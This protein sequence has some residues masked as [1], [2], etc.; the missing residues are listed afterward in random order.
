MMNLSDCS[1]SLAEPAEMPVAQWVTFCG[2]QSS[3]TIWS[4][5]YEKKGAWLGAPLTLFELLLEELEFE[6]DEGTLIALAIGTL[7]GASGSSMAPNPPVTS[8][9]RLGVNSA[10]WGAAQG[11]LSAT[12]TFKN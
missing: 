6:L 12:P 7:L 2:P 5:P 10:F 9:V 11:V 8:E 4:L 1:C 3:R